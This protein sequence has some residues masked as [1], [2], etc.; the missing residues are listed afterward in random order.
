MKDILEYTDYRL[1]I[2]D[3]Y[4]DRKAKSA[5]TWQEFANAAGFT[6]PVYLKYVSEGRFNLS[7]DAA[8]RVAQAM[9]LA[10]FEPEYF[11]EMV[12]FDHAKNDAEKKAA[13]NRMLAIADAHKAKILEG[14]SFRFFSDWKN[15]V[16]RELAPAMPGAKPLALAH[17][18]RPKVSAAEVSETLKFLVNADLLQKGEDGN[19]L[20]TEKSVTTGPM[21][22]TPVAVRGLHRQMGEIALEAIEGVSQD[23]RN[24]SGLTLGVT[25]GAYEE[26]VKEI[27]EFRKRVVAIA[28]R[29]DETDEVYRMNIQFFPMTNKGLNK[30]G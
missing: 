17:A 6:S 10:G 13:F 27:A 29:D 7:E 22:A 24:F 2:A 1:Y 25:R 12:K 18:C 20:Q 28:T 30:K 19:Y 5:F 26:I 4:A 21:N 11:C 14:D 9:D 23:D 3:Y 15:P 8:V 16:I